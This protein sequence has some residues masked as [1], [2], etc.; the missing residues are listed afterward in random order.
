MILVLSL[1]CNTSLLFARII[2]FLI[3]HCQKT[4]RKIAFEAANSSL[5]LFLSLSKSSVYTFSDGGDGNCPW[6]VWSF[7]WQEDCIDWQEQR[8][9]PDLCAQT[10][11][12]AEHAQDWWEDAEMLSISTSWKVFCSALDAIHEPLNVNILTKLSDFLV[13]VTTT[14]F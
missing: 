10:E 5:T 12:R 1:K 7:Q 6:P 14:A 3:W 9:L 8:L 13:M 11:Q 4:G 2:S